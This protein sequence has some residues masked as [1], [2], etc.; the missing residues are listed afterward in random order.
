[1]DVLNKLMHGESARLPS[2]VRVTRTHDGYHVAPHRP[3]K[4][5]YEA[6]RQALNLHDRLASTY[7]RTRGAHSPGARRGMASRARG[8]VRTEPDKLPNA[9]DWFR[10]EME[11]TGELDV[12]GTGRP[13]PD[14]PGYPPT[15][16][17][18]DTGTLLDE[19]TRER[20]Q[21]FSAARDRITRLQQRQRLA[22]AQKQHANALALQKELTRERARLSDIRSGKR[23]TGLADQDAANA[24]RFGT[25]LE[26]QQR[27]ARGA[28]T[29][30]PAAAT[31]E[32]AGLRDMP[33]HEIA[34]HI[35]LDW[36]SQGKGVNYAARPYLEALRYL[37][38]TKDNYGYD[39]GK[40]VVAYFLSNAGTW[41]GPKAKAIKAELK[42]RLRE[43]AEGEVTSVQHIIDRLEE[44]VEQRKEAAR[45][46]DTAEFTR[47]R[48]VE[49]VLTAKAR[50]NLPKSDFVFPEKA[51][52]SG[53]YPI[54]DRRH[55][56]NA[57]TRASG[58]PEYSAVKA[59]VC[60][61]YSDL[62]ACQ[63]D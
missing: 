61:R 2:G 27:I 14:R 31:D 44:A 29:V 15:G 3:T 34:D 40:S 52:G 60:A 18:A 35:A 4:S 23:D 20:M 47:L 21:D 32:V 42:R 36:G 10:R 62:P 26:R 28:E 57:L 50:K 25:T 13:H 63:G 43:S 38:S 49:A 19:R 48:A 41:K 55:G 45:R 51:P 24:R 9:P 8:T 1:V 5:T 22:I 12:L 6:A 58:K 33:L 59:K 7:G 39:S 46:G 54:H 37:S 53:S 17:K 30:S 16:G 11:R 56:A